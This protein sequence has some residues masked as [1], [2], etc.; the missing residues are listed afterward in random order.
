MDR[1]T[2]KKIFRAVFNFYEK[3]MSMTDVE[4]TV[5]IAEDEEEILSLFRNDSEA[6]EF[7]KEMIQLME[8]QI[9][10]KFNVKR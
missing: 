1:L 7:A 3:Y 5:H 9:E 6:Y 8:K 4:Q 10:R 2:G